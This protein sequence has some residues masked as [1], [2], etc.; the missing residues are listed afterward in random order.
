GGIILLAAGGLAY[1]V[2]IIFYAIRKKYMHSIWHF[3]VLTG[4][5]LQYFAVLFY[6]VM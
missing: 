2:G 1:T 4:T 6:V 5:I 3:F